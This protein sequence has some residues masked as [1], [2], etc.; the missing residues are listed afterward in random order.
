MDI[1]CIAGLW[2]PASIWEKTAEALR[3]KGHQ[4]HVVALPG[5]DDGNPEATLDDQLDAVLAAVDSCERPPLVVGH[6]AASTLAALAAD[7]RGKSV[8]GTV[9][10]GGYPTTEGEQYA[11]FAQVEGGVSRFPGWEPFEG[12]DS[13][14]LDDQAKERLAAEAV[15]VAG[16][17]A[18]GVVHW[19]DEARHKVPM[20][21]I[22]P[23]FTPD[24]AKEWIASGDVPELAA[25]TTLQ[26]VDL[27]SGHW[28][29]TSVPDELARVLD[30]VAQGLG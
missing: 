14:D 19:T 29:M 9:L 1:I 18:Q 17:V 26:F 11:G 24:Q 6:S 25:N 30:E 15:P 21:L 3:E 10:I 28:P 13:D 4:V 20:T 8:A 22:C 7:R 23:E 27:D 12:P 16:G 2:M 5:E